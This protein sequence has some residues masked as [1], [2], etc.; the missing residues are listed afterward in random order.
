[1]SRRL[2][3]LGAV[4]ASTALTTRVSAST[5][6]REPARPRTRYEDAI[7]EVLARKRAALTFPPSWETALAAW[8]EDAGMT[9][10]NRPAL[11]FDI[12]AGLL[13]D[14]IATFERVTQLHVSFAQV[15][16]GD[17]QSPGVTGVFTPEQAL[18]RLLEGTGATFA[19][20]GTDRVN[21]ELAAVRESVSV[22]SRVAV[23][24]PKLPQLI[25]DIPQT[26]SVIPKEVMQAQAATSLRDVL[27][28]V[29]GIT[30]QAGE[31]GGGL[32]GDT[33]TLRGFASGNDLFIDG[34]RDAGGYSRDAF[35][36]EQV[37]VAKGPSSSIAG[38]GTTGGA[39]NQVTKSPLLGRLSEATLVGGYPGTGR[40]TV[41]FNQ[42]IGEERRGISLRLNA[43]VG[44]ATVPG[45]DV[46]ENESWGVA[47]SFAIGIGQPTQFM[48]K[49][50]HLRQNNVP[51]YGL[52]W[53]VYPDYPTGAFDANPPVDQS[54]FYGLR[55]YD[56]EDIDSD[57]VSGEV[58]H[59]FGNGMTLR[60]LT[61][62]SDTNRESAITAPRPPNRQLQRR[63]MGNEQLANHTNLNAA[64][65]HGPVRHDL[66]SGIEIAR[67]MTSN[68]NSAQ[69]TNQPAVTVATPNPDERP[70]GP[71]PANIG[72][73]SET[74]LGLI[75]LYAFDTVSLGSRWQLTGGV[76]WDTVDVDYRLT[77]LATGERTEI[78]RSDDTL[79]WRAAAL[80]KPRV[81]ASLYLAFGT[82][83]NPSVD[84]G[85]T[86]AGFSTAPNAVN[87][88]NLEP[89]E[90]RSYEGG[91]KWDALSGRLAL[92]AAIFRTEKINARTRNLASE[93]FIL[94]GRQRVDGIELSAS[95]TLS[96][97][98]ALTA[99]YALMHSDIASSANPAE[100]GN[101]PAFTPENTFNLWTTY[102]LPGDVTVGAG[103]Q[104]MDSVYR[105]STNTTDVP[106]YW[107]LN[108]LASYRLNEHLTLR[109]N[110]QN[111]ADV[112]YVD[113]L[114]GGHYIPG[115]GR[116]GL[117][118]ADF[119]F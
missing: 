109:F 63:T 94:S 17:I 6:P 82:S 62:Y 37:E 28:N 44:D 117:L 3:L 52:P 29:P 90:T 85:T 49:S 46:V 88:P 26:I 112:D 43:M 95:G 99:A 86:G 9:A 64:Y 83:F 69:S 18:T 111:L 108:S 118:S 101:D 100:E 55:D 4:V 41:D 42:P 71:M 25:R 60:N 2:T 104:F 54:N 106:S 1:M 68:Q 22:S 15:A 19:M 74:G 47:P 16:L 57:V 51:D 76:R 119:R 32:P 38:R 56:F 87:N 84:A 13:R 7:A 67:E 10:Q 39:I 30:F 114:G 75:G 8:R 66:V 92:N 78:D 110:L 36:L 12:P 14:V 24:S 97:R 20:S 89:E 53:G 80:F 70:F 77:T 116:Q 65:R 73:P 102:S 40:G 103:V 59:R 107:L 23:S 27:R 45:R 11:R 31:G 48:I 34:V 98:W 72:N 96:D 5:E 105:N 35:N 91:A 61:R 79:S 81:E 33:F 93:P 113:R 115:P 21:I 50:Q 58:R